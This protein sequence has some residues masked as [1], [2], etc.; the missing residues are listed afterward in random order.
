[1]RGEPEFPQAGVPSRAPVHSSTVGVVAGARRTAR[2]HAFVYDAGFRR[3]SALA[4]A[5]AGATSPHRQPLRPRGPG[6]RRRSPVRGHRLVVDS[7]GATSAVLLWPAPLDDQGAAFATSSGARRRRSTRQPSTLP[8]GAGPR[9]SRR[10]RSRSSTSRH[11]S[12]RRRDY[13]SDPL[14]GRLGNRARSRT[15]AIGPP[16]AASWSIA[17]PVAAVSRHPYVALARAGDVAHWADRP[18]TWGARRTVPSRFSGVRVRAARARGC[19][20]AAAGEETDR[21]G[22]SCAHGNTGSRWVA[23]TRWESIAAL[24]SSG[25]TYRAVSPR[26]SRARAP[27]RSALGEARAVLGVRPRRTRRAIVIPTLRAV[28]CDR[29]RVRT[30]QRRV[31]G[32]AG[33]GGSSRPGRPYFALE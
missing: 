2:Q 12:R 22:D 18:S 15:S 24:N 10:L 20:P 17:R 16:E 31:N 30:R 7:T 28:A 3:Q 9:R 6:A 26:G 4:M 11:Q 29:C 32:T 23:A 8:R 19:R 5:H 1:M 13:S 27:P 25:H 14:D 21:F 33:R